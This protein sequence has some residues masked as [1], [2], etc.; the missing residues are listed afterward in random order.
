MVQ[1]LTRTPLK[2]GALS[3]DFWLSSATGETVTRHQ[4]RNKSALVVIMLS[5][6]DASLGYLR[7][8]VQRSDEFDGLNVRLVAALQAEPDDL[9]DPAAYHPAILLADPDHKAW[10]AYTESAPGGA[11]VFMLDLYGGVYE[12]CVVQA[13]SDLPTADKVLMWATGAQYQCNI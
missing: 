1:P 2:Y 13:V 4:F 11:A 7:E 8:L 5:P 6:T 12:Q 9:P 10:D 3:P